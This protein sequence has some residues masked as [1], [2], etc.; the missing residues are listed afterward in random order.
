MCSQLSTTASK[1]WSQSSTTASYFCQRST[2]FSTFSACFKLKWGSAGNLDL[3]F[4]FRVAPSFIYIKS[5]DHFSVPLSATSSCSRAQSGGFNL[6]VGFPQERPIIIKIFYNPIW[7][8]QLLKISRQNFNFNWNYCKFRQQL[9][10][11]RIFHTLSTWGN[12]S[13]N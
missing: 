1:K 7:T 13:G 2:R 5:T 9:P 10:T 11:F 12:E 3:I 6:N 4:R 8:L